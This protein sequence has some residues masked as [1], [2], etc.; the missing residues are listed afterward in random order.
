MLRL[1]LCSLMAFTIII[2]STFA[3]DINDV[4]EAK[5]RKIVSTWIN[6]QKAMHNH[7]MISQFMTEGDILVEQTS[8]YY[9]VTL[10]KITYSIPSEG[11]IVID[12]ISINAIP[13]DD[14][15]DWKIS[16][17]LPTSITST[18]ASD[19]SITTINFG[20]QKMSG[21]W[22]GDLNSFSTIDALYKD[23]NITNTK[24]AEV[25]MI[26][27]FKI[28]GDLQETENG[29]W[30]GPSKAI[31]NGVK[32]K[33]GVDTIISMGTIDGMVQITDFSPSEKEETIAKI[34]QAQENNEPLD[35][36]SLTGFS[37]KNLGIN[38]AVKDITVNMPAR[39]TAKGKERKATK[40]SLA[41]ATLK[42]KSKAVEDDKI[43]YD[44]Q[45]GYN[46]LDANNLKELTP[47]KFKIGFAF[48]NLPFNELKNMGMKLSSA[49]ASNPNSGKIAALQ[50]MMTLPQ[51]LSQA[52]TTLQITDTGVSND[53]YQAV[54]S[55]DL[56]ASAA[57]PIGIIGD[58]TM[59]LKG[60]SK[61]TENLEEEKIDATPK[62]LKQINSALKNIQM[63]QLFSEKSG[64]TDI[65]NLTISEAGK[66]LINDKD[67]SLLMGQK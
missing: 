7:P 39:K 20:P 57:S 26:D 5:L 30:S 8:D 56:K 28:I 25:T 62:K 48:E 66:I 58:V 64:D 6:D 11:E 14:P 32:V 40:F 38:M 44:F 36:F 29:K 19:N 37:S 12:L 17:S 53:N 27:S 59:R 47:S 65:L 61:I 55:G 2:P 50:S 67:I 24:S 15:E 10:P 21:L 35:L 54:V 42:M 31:I 51:I 3:A 43:N 45:M 18:K 13:T 23:I 16:L 46:G 34:K 9:A 60:L 41:D 49:S 4:G 63:V 1:L 52:K 33:S 22:S